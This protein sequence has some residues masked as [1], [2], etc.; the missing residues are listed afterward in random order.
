MGEP[1][2]V[3]ER[4]DHTE[5]TVLEACVV[6]WSDDGCIWRTLGEFAAGDVY[7]DF[8][9]SERGRHYATVVDGQ[10]RWQYMPLGAAKVFAEVMEPWL[11]SRAPADRAG[12]SRRHR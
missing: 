11:P 10:I 5:I 2:T 1:L 12:S 6:R 3:A 4:G 9:A 8:E 7:R